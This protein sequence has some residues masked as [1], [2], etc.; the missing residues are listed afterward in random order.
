MLAIPDLLLGNLQGVGD[1]GDG[2]ALDPAHVEQV[3]H[4]QAPSRCERIECTYGLSAAPLATRDL[5][6]VGSMDG[7]LRA[8][9]AETGEMLWEFDAWQNFVSVNDVITTGGAFDGHGPMVAGN[10]LVV[11]AGYSYV[12]QQRGGNALLVFHLEEHDE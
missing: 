5:V 4:H 12:G 6:F 7:Y 3:W 9:Q 1:I 2:F 10:T 11:S 8:L